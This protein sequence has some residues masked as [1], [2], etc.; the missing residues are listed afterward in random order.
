L[1]D[2][3]LPR[4]D[5]MRSVIESSAVGALVVATA[6]D[7]ASA[8]AAARAN[9]PNVA[10]LEIQ[11]PV[12]AALETVAALRHRFPRLPI[13]VCSFRCDTTT[14]ARAIAQGADA[15]LEKP[16]SAIGLR[17][18]FAGLAASAGSVAPALSG[19]PVR[20]QEE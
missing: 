8:V 10:V 4:R 11:L 7:G 12:E 5:V 20:R 6:A 3:V 9:E 13:V 14:K 19:G 15:Y 17:E 18:T 1:I 16:L 2:K